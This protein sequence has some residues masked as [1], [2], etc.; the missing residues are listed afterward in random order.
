[1]QFLLML[2][3]IIFFRVSK[4]DAN[5]LVDNFNMKIPLDDTREKKLRC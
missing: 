2:L 5:I 1:M 4:M 3:T